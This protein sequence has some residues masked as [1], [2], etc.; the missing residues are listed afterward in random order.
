MIQVEIK[1]ALVSVFD[2]CKPQFFVA[3]FLIA[4]TM[5]N[6]RGDCLF[7]IQGWT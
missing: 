1:T 2:K 3:T 7:V 5:L 4:L 6:S